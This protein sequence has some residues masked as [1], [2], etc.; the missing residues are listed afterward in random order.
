MAVSILVFLTIA[1]LAVRHRFFRIPVG[2]YEPQSRRMYMALAGEVL[3]EKGYRIAGE[4]LAHEMETYLGARKF[5][6]YVVADFLAERDGVLYPVKVRSPR[7][8][9]RLDGPWIRKQFYPLWTVY[10]SPVAYVNPEAASIELI[11]FSVDY[12]GR[13]FGR[14]WRS[15]LIW[16]VVGVAAGWLLSLV[17]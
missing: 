13:Y 5:T 4:R 6:S 7:D 11:D 1:F 10:E 15:R 16:L 8:P 14:R 3:Q 17:K 9:E 2:E 12:P